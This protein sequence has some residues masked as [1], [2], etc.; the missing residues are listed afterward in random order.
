MPANLTDLEK[1]LWDAA[2]ELRANSKL[3]ASEYSAPVLGLIFLRFADFKF[4]QAEQQFAA[5]PAGARRP[6]SSSWKPLA[7]ASC[8]CPPHWLRPTCPK[9]CAVSVMPVIAISLDPSILPSASHPSPVF[10]QGEGP[11]RSGGMGAFPAV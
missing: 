1:R 5:R 9:P 11:K 7:C 8:A 2:D 10:S 6:A 4:A 3:K